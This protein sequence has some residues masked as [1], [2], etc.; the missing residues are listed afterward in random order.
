MDNNTQ[1]YTILSNF[2]HKA[3]ALACS[4]CLL[5]LNAMSIS[6]AV[7]ACRLTKM[8]KVLLQQWQGCLPLGDAHDVNFTTWGSKV[9]EIMQKT[10]YAYSLNNVQLNMYEYKS[11][12]YMDFKDRQDAVGPINGSMIPLQMVKEGEAGVI[13]VCALR[14]LS[15]VLMEISEF[16]NSPT[17]EMIASS[18]EQWKDCYMRLY[19]K[20]CE[21]RYDKWKLRFPP[22]MLKKNVQERMQKEMEAF[23]KKFLNGDDEFDIVYD[24]ELKDIDIE[25]VSR[26][27]FTNSER[28]GVSHMDN[29]PMFSKELVSL[30]NYVDIW[31][32]MQKDLQPKRKQAE[33]VV[34]PVV[35]ELEV[36]VKEVVGKIRHLASTRWSQQLPNLWKGIFTNFRSEISKA[37]VREK[38]KEYSKKTLYCIIGHLKAKGVYQ[39]QVSVLELTKLLEGT[40]NGTRKYVNN[41][42][43][44]LEE[45]LK[46]RI[47][48]FVEQE[49]Q[50]LLAEA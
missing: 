3:D 42:L 2:E 9:W 39:K 24:S 29:R 27:L 48:L 32:M 12:C 5:S 35:D 38:F 16:L 8:F 46:E 21:K 17:E 41:G 34:A 11:D 23:R 7:D 36:K 18:F 40:N 30:F 4:S 49:M 43:I 31:R 26:F 47:E 19:H 13:L 15:E 10:H 28:F 25:G 50:R 44:E 14:E 45:S 22:R 1:E 20:N 6:L 33:K 37:G